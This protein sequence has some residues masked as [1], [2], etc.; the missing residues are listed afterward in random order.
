MVFILLINRIMC[1]LNTPLQV[2]TMAP[3]LH[4]LIVRKRMDAADILGFLFHNHCKL[5]KLRLEH[6]WLGKDGSGL[7]ATFV[8]LYPDLVGLSLSYCRP[9]RPDSY[10]HIQRLKKLSELKL[11]PNCQVNY[12]Y[13][14]L[15]QSHVCI[16]EHI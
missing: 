7:L 6:C 13:V 14:N 10:D 5:R 1:R 9:L 12:M 4:S 3:A 15:L 8:D 2:L 11:S 16:C